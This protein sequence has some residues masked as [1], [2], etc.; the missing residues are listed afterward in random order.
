MPEQNRLET[1]FDRSISRL[2]EDP[3]AT[4]DFSRLNKSPNPQLLEKV[5]KTKQ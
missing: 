5:P 1:K 4:N 2:S 3:A